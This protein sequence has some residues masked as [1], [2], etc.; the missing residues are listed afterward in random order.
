MLKVIGYIGAGLLILALTVG[1]GIK[2]TQK[3]EGYRAQEQNFYSFEP[4]FFVGGCARY[5]ATR[6]PDD[7][8]KKIIPKVEVKKEVNN[9]SKKK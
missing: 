9:G 3:A 1:I 5:E 8:I 6:K 4:H 2:L 7:K